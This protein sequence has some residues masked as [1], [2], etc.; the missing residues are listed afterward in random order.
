[1][2]K[3]LNSIVFIHDQG[4]HMP[5]GTKP[6]PDSVSSCHDL[7]LQEHHLISTQIM[8]IFILENASENV[9]KMSA[10]LFMT[11]CVSNGVT[12]PLH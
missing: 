11:K 8:I 5:D 12:S 9:C 7:E 3:K 4:Q 1:M 10:I 6:L 2:Q